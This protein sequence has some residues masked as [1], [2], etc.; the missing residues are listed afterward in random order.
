MTEPKDPLRDKITET[1]T[2][3]DADDFAIVGYDSR[4]IA[5]FADE[6]HLRYRG[7]IMLS[8]RGEATIAH[9]QR[10]FDVGAMSLIHLLPGDSL[11][12]IAVSDDFSIYALSYPEKIFDEMMYNFPSSFINHIVERPA[13]RLSDEEF[14]A[15]GATYFRMISSKIADRDN[16]C[17]HEIVVNL[18][19]NFYLEIYDKV[20]RFNHI[21]TSQSTHK[22]RIW[23]RFI[24]LLMAHPEQRSVAYFADALCIT[25]KY[26]SVISSEVSG[27]P[28]KEFIARGTVVEI[29]QALR[30]T[31]MS[32]KQIAERFNFAGS[33]NMCRFFKAN[34]GITIS[35]FRRKIRG[36]AE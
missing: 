30:T 10:R 15:I 20:V 3:D 6:R 28:A 9:N 4:T 16:I 35:A 18:L 1:A 34:T 17:R 23:D 29:K 8:V 7:Y 22:R 27:L 2:T 14:Y 31:D 5:R 32:V 36:G 24:T 13:Y 26:L 33:S 12:F 11:A 21:D 25:P 19:R